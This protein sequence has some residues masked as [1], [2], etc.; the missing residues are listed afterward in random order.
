MGTRSVTRFIEILDDNGKK[1]ERVL[2]AIYQQYDGYLDGVGCEIAEFL[3]PIKMVNGIGSDNENIANGI[4]CLAAQFIAKFKTRV[5]GLYMTSINDVQEYN[6]DILV[7]WECEGF[8]V[9]P[10]QPIIR[11][12]YYGKSFEGTVAEFKEFISN[13]DY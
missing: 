3:Q 12:E 2:C 10:T 13:S 1:E 5:G 8:N 11:V 7:G 6:Y 4:G 9:K